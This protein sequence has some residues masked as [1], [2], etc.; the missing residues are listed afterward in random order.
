M[1]I[2]TINYISKEELQQIIGGNIRKI[3]YQKNINLMKL[4]EQVDISYEYLRSIVSP[5][6]K[7]N[8]SF[9]SVYKFSKAL[10]TTI[11]EL[12]KKT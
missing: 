7:K 8:L 3:A 9:Y 10:D 6:G 4:S 5:K 1:S 12:T 11:D 2:E